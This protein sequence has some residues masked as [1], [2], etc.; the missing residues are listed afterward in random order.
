L[1]IGTGFSLSSLIVST[2]VSMTPANY[3]TACTSALTA[4][5]KQSGLEKNVNDVQGKITTFADKESKEYIGEKQLKYI[6]SALFIKKI[7]DER[8]VSLQLPKVFLYDSAS[9]EL[10][11]SSCKLNLQWNF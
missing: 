1:D 9:T 8:K 11:E 2:C 3:N 4:G 7:A 6:G 5:S 10:S